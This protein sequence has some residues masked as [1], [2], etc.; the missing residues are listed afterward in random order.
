MLLSA[1]QAVYQD[2]INVTD[3][4]LSRTSG[5]LLVWELYSKIEKSIYRG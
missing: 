1:S 4:E 5:R 3:P 2:E